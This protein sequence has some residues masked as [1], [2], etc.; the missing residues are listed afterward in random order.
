M[1][2]HPL[3]IYNLILLKIQCR[4]IIPS[5]NVWAA[6]VKHTTRGPI[7]TNFPGLGCMYD[8]TTEHSFDLQATMVIG[9][10]GLISGM[11]S[12]GVCTTRHWQTTGRLVQG[13]NICT[14]FSHHSDLVMYSGAI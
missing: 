4:H 7:T 13:L 3:F 10:L 9:V 11:T 1:V 8:L 14:V 2:V 5:L 6:R 12:M